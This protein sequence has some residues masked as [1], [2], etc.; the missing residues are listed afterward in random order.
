MKL[1]EFKCSIISYV[2]LLCT[3]NIYAQDRSP[4][5]NQ[6]GSVTFRIYN[7]NVTEVELNGTM[8]PESRK[9]KTPVGTFGKVG[10]VQ[11]TLSNNGWWEYTIASIAPGLYTY[12]YTMDDEQFVDSLNPNIMRE[13]NKYVSYFIV[14]GGYADDYELKTVPH[15]QVKD[16]WYPSSLASFDKRRMMVYFPYEYTQNKTKHYPV[17]YLL[18][19]SGGDEE[20]WLDCGRLAQIMD[21][22]IY[23]KR[24]KPMIVVMP[25]GIANRA[26]A[27]GK[28]PNN[29]DLKSSSINVESMLGSI[30]A[31]F[32]KDIVDYVD[33]NF[34]TIN[35]KKCRAIAGLSLGGLQTIFVSLNNPSMFDYIGLFSAQ[36][37]NALDDKYISDL[38]KLSESWN[39]L[40]SVFPMLKKK[41]LG[42]KISE[43][44]N[45]MSGGAIEIYSN[46]D[47]KLT[48][49]FLN[50]PQLYYI[51]LGRD[52][53]VKKLNDDFRAKLDKE[54]YEYVYIE[55]DGGHT[56]DNWRKYLVDFLPRLF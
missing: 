9:I 54:G 27:P 51:T 18:H 24:C 6:D 33:E 35:S 13:G 45:N 40:S 30:E 19:G 7:P 17:L 37:T 8:L 10:K 4:I 26:A 43:I 50:P 55:T 56:W 5:I 41:G 25:N 38:S 15:G 47:N 36:S 1:K 32:V 22:L 44:S 3:I 16:V 53:F 20:S 46:I 12:S 11:M 34:R 42:K 48:E 14:K 2:I 52:D 23:E 49:Q 39:N 31:V 21:N 28:D 29:P